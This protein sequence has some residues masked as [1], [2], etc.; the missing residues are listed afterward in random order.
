MKLTLDIWRQR[1]ADSEGHYETYDVDD[2]D[3]GMSIPEVLDVLNERLTRQGEEP[4]VFETDCRESICGACGLTIDGHPHGPTPHLTTCMQRLWQFTDGQ[5]LQLEPLR[6]GAFRLVR[7]LMV[8]RSPLDRI[9]AAGG[10]VSVDAG[11]AP[12]AEALPVD[13][14]T[15]ETALDF[16]T[17]IGCG[18]C[19]AACPNGAANLFTG[20]K[21]AHL[22]LLP[23]PSVERNRRAVRMVAAMEEEF[24]ACSLYG[25]CEHVC[26]EEIKLSAVAALQ[27][28]RLGAALA[29]RL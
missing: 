27:H 11:S 14:A 17:C 22:S 25:E 24:G 10:N 6:S 28:E 5:R 15:A 2:L 26:P 3:V 9:I 23:L 18:A 8:D 19:V 7:D 1:S 12:D 29:R 21:L 20:A 4:I 13:H 16:A